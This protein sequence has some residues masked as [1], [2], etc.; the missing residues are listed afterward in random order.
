MNDDI[1][2]TR[3][4]KSKIVKPLKGGAFNFKKWRQSVDMIA[5]KMSLKK[6]K[7]EKY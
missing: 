7:I 3:S 2:D 1:D 6:E 5:K 4:V